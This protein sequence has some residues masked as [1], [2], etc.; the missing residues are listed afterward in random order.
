MDAESRGG[1]DRLTTARRAAR[2]G[3]NVA[4]DLFREN[5]AVDSGDTRG[6]RRKMGT[7]SPR[8]YQIPCECLT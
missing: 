7:S 6:G 5:L 3:G 8:I 2:S 4:L 1:S